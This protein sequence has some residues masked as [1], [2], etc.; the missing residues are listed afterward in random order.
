MS[1]LILAAT[2][3][4]Q[5]GSN[6]SA[7]DDQGPPPPAEVAELLVSQPTSND[8]LADIYTR[9][10]PHFLRGGDTT[11]FVA[12]LEPAE[13]SADSMVR[14]FEALGRWS[15]VDRLSCITCPT[16][17]LAGR[18]DVFCSPPQLARIAQRVSD[19]TYVVFEHSGHF[20]WLE[21]AERFFTLVS[22]WLGNH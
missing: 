22:A 9:L 7:D 19:A 2:T 20:M 4:G 5:L 10:A 14:V 18:H 16:L 8:E 12:E 17:I 15:A 1:A 3:P 21:E 11:A 6:E 13:V